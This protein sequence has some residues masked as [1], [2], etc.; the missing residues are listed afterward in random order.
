MGWG[1]AAASPLKRCLHVCPC[2]N[3]PLPPTM[4]RPLGGEYPGK[5]YCVTHRLALFFLERGSFVAVS[6]PFSSPLSSVQASLPSLLQTPEFTQQLP[7][8][9]SLGQQ[10]GPLGPFP[11]PGFQDLQPGERSFCGVK[12][13]GAC[14]RQEA[15]SMSPSCPRSLEQ[16]SIRA[17][18]QG[19]DPGSTHAAPGFALC[20]RLC[21]HLIRPSQHLLSTLKSTE[22]RR[23]ITG[24]DPWGLECAEGV[25]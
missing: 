7:S 5:E 10:R 2:H 16:L 22:R 18:A 12:E 4:A 3:C 14:C 25:Q 6:S 17:F 20:T 13:R 24:P 1:L 23:P 8:E 11:E 15:Q 19:W 9:M 21:D